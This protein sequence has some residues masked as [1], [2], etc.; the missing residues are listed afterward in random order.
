MGD[1]TATF[2]LRYLPNPEEGTDYAMDKQFDT[3]ISASIS[4]SSSLN[5]MLSNV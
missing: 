2:S 3:S 4:S 5:P 1:A